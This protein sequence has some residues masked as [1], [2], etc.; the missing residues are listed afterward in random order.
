MYEAGQNR[1]ASTVWIFGARNGGADVTAESAIARARGGTKFTVLASTA[2]GGVEAI[3]PLER[4]VDRSLPGLDRA[5][6][7]AAAPFTEAGEICSASDVL[8]I[9]GAGKSENAFGFADR[10]D[11]QSVPGK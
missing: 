9:H 1:Q 8:G 7:N 6:A 10:N 5:R 4:N 3:F 11:H 2:A